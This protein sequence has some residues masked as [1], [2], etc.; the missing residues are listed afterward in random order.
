MAY[1]VTKLCS[2]HIIGLYSTGSE[3]LQPLLPNTPGPSAQHKESPD[4]Y[5]VLWE[6]SYLSP[7]YCKNFCKKV[8]NYVLIFAQVQ[9]YMY[10]TSLH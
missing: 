6:I 5:R 7:K 2:G 10:V 8:Q 3:G 1:M 9:A 4:A